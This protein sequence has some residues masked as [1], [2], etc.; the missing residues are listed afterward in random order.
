MSLLGGRDCDMDC[1]DVVSHRKLHEMNLAGPCGFYCGTCRH[2]LARAKGLLREK[3]LKHG[4]RGCRIQD[5]NCAWVK[6]DCALLRKKQIDFCFECNEFPCANLGKF[7]E[8][9]RRD[10][11]VSPIANLLRI[12]KIGVERWLEE[13]AGEWRCSQCGGTICVIDRQCYD[14]EY[15]LE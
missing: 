6:R 3:K 8:R 15:K 1:G 4:C 12:Q 13:Q 2:Y 11:G 9:H 10:D 14:C 5:K 7:D